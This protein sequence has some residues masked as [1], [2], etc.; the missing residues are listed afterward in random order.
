MAEDGSIYVHLA[1]NIAHY[2][3]MCMDEVFG[4]TFFVN[5]IIWQRTSSHNDPNRY[6]N[7]VDV[8]LYYSKSANRIW[9]QLYGN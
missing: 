8:L 9:N 3:K 2:V 4:S 6:G 7:N 5:E 1:N